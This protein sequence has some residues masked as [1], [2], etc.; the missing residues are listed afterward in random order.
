MKKALLACAPA[1]LLGAC[2]P[3]KTSE[4]I[5]ASFECAAGA[6]LSITFENKTGVAIVRTQA[7]GLHVL[8]RTIS[9]SGYSYEADGR[10]LRGKGR[11]AIW[12]DM[13]AAP[14]ACQE[15]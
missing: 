4:T 13:G 2:A 5:E 7:G 9:G 8:N 11:E 1:L 6:R 3:A 15:K 12:T 10:T 14:L